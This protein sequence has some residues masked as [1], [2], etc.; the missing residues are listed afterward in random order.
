MTFYLTGWCPN[1]GKA[2]QIANPEPNH[3]VDVTESGGLAPADTDI[4][5]MYIVD[6]SG[7]DVLLAAPIPPSY[8][9]KEIIV[10]KPAAAGTV[11]IQAYTGYK[12]VDNAE[13]DAV[14]LEDAGDYVTFKCT[15]TAYQIVDGVY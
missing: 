12:F 6:A 7:G 9:G 2:F 3:V 1:C 14:V 5:T 4:G 11:T 13:A 15:A 8:E 10:K